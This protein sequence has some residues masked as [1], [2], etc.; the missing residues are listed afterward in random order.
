MPPPPGSLLRLLR[1]PPCT[2]TCWIHA[3]PVGFN[4]EFTTLGG[5]C[6]LNVVSSLR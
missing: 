1:L 3:T 2:H 5:H 4:I 6:L